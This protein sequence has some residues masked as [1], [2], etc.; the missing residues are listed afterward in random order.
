MSQ[1]KPNCSY[2]KHQNVEYRMNS[3][4]N[5]WRKAF[6]CAVYWIGE[7]KCDE[8]NYF[9]TSLFLAR[10]QLIGVAAPICT[11]CDESAL[12]ALANRA[13]QLIS[14]NFVI[15]NFCDWF[16]VQC[17][18]LLYT[19]ANNVPTVNK[20]IRT[21]LEIRFAF[22]LTWSQCKIT[23]ALYNETLLSAKCWQVFFG[24]CRPGLIS[25]MHS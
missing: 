17:A 16:L 1:K 23:T 7:L 14:S 22:E 21:H 4:E 19:C 15:S 24:R 5:H 6:L 11:N 9:E 13:L 20:V 3:I 2:L 12:A 8:W 18:H 10:T 25:A